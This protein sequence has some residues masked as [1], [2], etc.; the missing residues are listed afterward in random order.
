MDAARPDLVIFDCDGVLV[1]SELLASRL[2]AEALAAEGYAV[3]EADCRAR[4][5]GISIRSV[6][7]IIE[8]ERGTPL[9]ADFEDKVRANDLAVFA[10][11]LKAVPGVA[12]ALARIPTAKCVASSGAPE[13]IRHSLTVTGLIDFFAPHLFSAHMV[14]RGKPAPDLFLFAAAKMG[15][16]AARC[17][18]VEDSAAGV[19]AAGAAGM[20]VL[21]FAGGGH[22]GDGYAAMLKA[23]GAARVFDDMAELPA[24]LQGVSSSG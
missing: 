23:T 10:R 21:G 20:P 15:V 4:F 19:A 3:T 22:A 16:E 17:V 11:E 2:L 14:R 5:T 6:I 18:V 24:L 1:D 7:E 8:A 13:K 9:P 12:A